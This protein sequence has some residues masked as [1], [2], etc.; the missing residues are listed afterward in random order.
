MPID[1]IYEVVVEGTLHGSQCL[2]VYHF[3]GS[4]NFASL[5]GVIAAVVDCVRTTLLPAL[6]V[7]Y[8]LVAVRG[9][10]IYPALSDEQITAGGAGDVGSITTDSDVSFAAALL[11]MK[12]GLGG[13]QNRGRKFLAGIPESGISKSELTIPELALIVTFATCLADKFIS[14]L[15]SFPY[16]IGVLRRKMLTQ[17][18][19]KLAAF[20]PYTSIVTSTVIAT[21]RRRKKGI[22]S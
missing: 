12:T 21:Q 5:A 20:Q 19:S 18:S 1:D 3:K 13:R 6:S 15:S 8:K 4:N 2:N 9:K 16:F 10:T 7:D 22:G 11:S 17:G 14:G